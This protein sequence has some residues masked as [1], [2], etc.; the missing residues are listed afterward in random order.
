M[1]STGGRAALCAALLSLGDP[2]GSGLPGVELE[3][4]VDALPGL[5]LEGLDLEARAL[6]Q[7]VEEAEGGVD[8][9]PSFHPVR[10]PD[11]T[12]TM[13]VPERYLRPVRSDE[14][15]IVD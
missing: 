9:E 15:I 1:G 10:N 7:K 13:W 8:V 3:V 12:I 11:G 2:G 5:P 14:T 4:G 6:L